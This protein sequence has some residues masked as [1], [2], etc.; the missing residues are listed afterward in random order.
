LKYFIVYEDLSVETFDGVQLFIEGVR[1]AMDSGNKF[2]CF[3][4]DQVLFNKDG[5]V[6]SWGTQRVFLDDSIVECTLAQPL[7]KK[8]EDDG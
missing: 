6:M 5:S 4:G 1:K 8:E 2:I 7:C 3:V